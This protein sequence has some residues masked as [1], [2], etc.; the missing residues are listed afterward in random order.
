MGLR[1][2]VTLGSYRSLI[3]EV[4]NASPSGDLRGGKN[5]ENAYR[6]GGSTNVPKKPEQSC[7]WKEVQKNSGVS[8]VGR[9]L[10]DVDQRT[11]GRARE[12]EKNGVKRIVGVVGGGGGRRSKVVERL[13]DG[14]YK[15]REGGKG[16]ERGGRWRG[17]IPKVK[18]WG[19]KVEV[20]G[21]GWWIR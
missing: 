18:R 10:K 5:G 8:G 11:R 14:R 12:K 19:G 20:E 6:G 9:G 13:R 3:G 21:E 7:S 1:V 16:E 15:K 2:T 4:N 17:E